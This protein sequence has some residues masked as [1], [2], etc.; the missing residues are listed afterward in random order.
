MFSCEFC[1]IFNNSFFIEYLRWYVCAKEILNPINLPKDC[2]ANILTYIVNVKHLCRS[3]WKIRKKN[4][5]RSWKITIRWIKNLRLQLK[6]LLFSTNAMQKETSLDLTYRPPQHWPSGKEITLCWLL[7]IPSFAK[8]GLKISLSVFDH[9]V[10]LALKGWVNSWSKCI[11]GRIR[12]H[13]K[14]LGWSILQK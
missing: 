8:L 2:V 9:F 14:H 1:K 12:N 10:G 7:L 13:V 6:I 5:R 11:Q 4:Y 3:T